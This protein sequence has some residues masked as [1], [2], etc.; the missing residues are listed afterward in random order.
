MLH[1]TSSTR[2]CLQGY[3]TTFLNLFSVMKTDTSESLWKDLLD[4]KLDLKISAPI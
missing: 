3:L 1:P 4:H 2:Y